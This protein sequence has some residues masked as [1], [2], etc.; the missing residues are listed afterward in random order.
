MTPYTYKGS[1]HC[2]AIHVTLE[3]TRP[4]EETQVRSCQCSFCLRQGSLTISDPLGRAV[5]EIGDKTLTRY[6]FGT[7]TATSL[8]CTKCG[9]YVGV[10]LEADGGTWSVANT[11]G[12]G[13]S[14]F[15]D[16]TGVP[17]LYE[18][19][20]PDERVARRKSKWTPTEI[21]FKT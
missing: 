19:E 3:M 14:E 8:I 4:A 20:T 17:M 7:E 2:G 21:R 13:I 15:Q 11:R 18:H 5:I 10:V 9:V 16:R 1:C 12:L 6:K